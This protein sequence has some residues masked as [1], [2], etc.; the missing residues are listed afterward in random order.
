MA[1][2]HHLNDDNRAFAIGVGLNVLFVAIGHA[3]I[4][5]EYQGDAIHCMLAGPDSCQGS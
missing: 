4:Q 1:H 2:E 3:T 5:V